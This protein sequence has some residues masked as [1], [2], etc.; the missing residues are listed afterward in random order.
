M[1]VVVG[2]VFI[3]TACSPGRDNRSEADIRRGDTT[4]WP[5]HFG[6]GRAASAAEIEAWD[7]D[8]R[9]DGKGLPEGSGSVA[10][11]SVLYSS[12]CARCHGI[13]GWG[14]PYM[15]LVGHADT[16][17]VQSERAVKTIGNYWPYATTLYDY[18]HRAMPYDSAGSLSPAEVYSITAWLLYA[19]HIIDSTAVITAETLPRIAMPAQPLFIPDD[20][21]GGSEVR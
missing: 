4:A 13:S 6:F 3:M 20:R 21:R 5:V 16:A 17:A 1:S 14:G 10:A 11:G 18:I 9:P 19:N 2:C 8:V 12:R 15:A 7:I